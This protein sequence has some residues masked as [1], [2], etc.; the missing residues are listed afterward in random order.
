[1]SLKT[2]ITTEQKIIE[3]A[4]KVFVEKG[5]DGARMQHIADEAG[6]NKSL[7]HYYFRSKEKLFD[8]IFYDV[9]RQFMPKVGMIMMSELSL[10]EK[11]RAF[12]G[13]YMD[14]LISNPFLPVF[15]LNELSHRPEKILNAF[16][17][18]G[19]NPGML[20][21]LLKTEVQQG[22]IVEIEAT[23]LMVNIIGMCVF[24]MVGRPI[25][26]GFIFQGDVQKYKQFLSERKEQI[27]DFVINSIKK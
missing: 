12:V 11:I 22:H 1:M 10:F 25:I 26:Q 6:I 23:H 21:H 24:T 3:A 14:M 5:F 27:A 2:T 15:V 18:T 8:A 7:L 20:N 19:I 17:D 16:K 9:F 13:Q 4:K